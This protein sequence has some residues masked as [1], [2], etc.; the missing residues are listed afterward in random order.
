[1]ETFLRTKKVT[2]EKFFENFNLLKENYK[3]YLTSI[4]MFKYDI[5]EK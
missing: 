2:L 3:E 4:N 1:M 5:L